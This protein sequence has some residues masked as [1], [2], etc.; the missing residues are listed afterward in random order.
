MV[1]I[2]AV[3][4][5]LPLVVVAVCSRVALALDNLERGLLE[6]VAAGA[7]TFEL[8]VFS[9]CICE[10]RVVDAKLF[11]TPAQEESRAAERKT[12]LR[13]F[14]MSP[15]PRNIAR[16]SLCSAAF[17]WSFRFFAS[18]YECCASVVVVTDGF[19]I[20]ACRSPLPMLLDMSIE[21]TAVIVLR[22]R[23]R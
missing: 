12:I 1:I 4:L 9:V 13:A 20:S 8:F 3:E 10:R 7:L 16:E 22:K 19:A 23:F 14:L 11:A 17:A 18:C 5:E 15:I 2:F 21:S 6:L